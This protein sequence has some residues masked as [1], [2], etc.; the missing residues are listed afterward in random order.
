M[1]MTQLYAF[2]FRKN[3]HLKLFDEIFPSKWTEFNNRPDR[4]NA[5]RSK[6][7]AGGAAKDRGDAANPIKDRPLLAQTAPH[8]NIRATGRLVHAT[9][10]G[11]R[12]SWFIRRATAAQDAKAR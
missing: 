1:S 4:V 6:P 7:C 10:R 12:W 8:A 11:W 5:G 2:E 9:E 3:K